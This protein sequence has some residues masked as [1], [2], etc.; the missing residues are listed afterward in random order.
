MRSKIVFK[1]MISSLIL[2]VI[3]II[4]GFVIPRLRI[5]CYGSDVNGLVASI[6]KFLAYITLLEFGFGPVVKSVLYKPIAQ[7][8]KE[9]IEQILKASERFFKHIA[10][11]FIAYIAILCVAMSLFVENE[12][13]AVYTISLVL[14]ISL[15]T[16]AEYFFGMTYRLYIQAEQREY[17]ISI[18]Q[19]GSLIINTI[20]II[21]MMK[22]GL[23]IHLVKLTSAL[24]FIMRPI[25]QNVYIKKK[26]NINLRKVKR[27]L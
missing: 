26:Y 4:C 15:S 20:I 11:I 12:F 22:C 18:I 13:N 7:K 19:A 16:F 17:V 9:E 10:Y 27:K 8:S 3:T 6:T 25:L 5:E 24:I 1:N 14:I 21:V 23:S 2:Q